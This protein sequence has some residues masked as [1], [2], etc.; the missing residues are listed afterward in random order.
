MAAASTASVGIDKESTI[1]HMKTPGRT[2]KH[3]RVEQLWVVQQLRRRSR[4]VERL[5]FQPDRFYPIT[6]H[7]HRRF[8]SRLFCQH[9]LCDWLSGWWRCWSSADVFGTKSAWTFRQPYAHQ[10]CSSCVVPLNPCIMRYGQTGALALPASHITLKA[11]QG[12][13][14]G[15]PVCTALSP[16]GVF[17]PLLGIH[18]CET[19]SKLQ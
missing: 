10:P 1:T 13:C 7:V 11:D 17:W 5:I 6:I 3:L 2:V 15:A 16:G 4:T 12:G 14:G 8:E 9:S 18:T 19:P